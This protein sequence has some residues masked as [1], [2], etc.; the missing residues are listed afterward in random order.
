MRR[1]SASHLQLRR[2]P[3]RNG[4]GVIFESEEDLGLQQINVGLTPE[5]SVV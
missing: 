2:R 1:P 3:K 5:D 4:F